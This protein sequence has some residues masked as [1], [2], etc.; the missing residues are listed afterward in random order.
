ME[1][2][3]ERELKKISKFD[4]LNFEWWSE[5]CGNLLGHSDV[6][7][8]VLLVCAAYFIRKSGFFEIDLDWTL[9]WLEFESISMI[10]SESELISVPS[11]K[12]Q[13]KL[14][15]F[16]INSRDKIGIQIHLLHVL[17]Q[18]LIDLASNLNFQIDFSILDEILNFEI[19]IWFGFCKLISNWTGNAKYRC[20]S[21]WDR[22]GATLILM[23][24]FINLDVKTSCLQ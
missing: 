2:K 15:K 18:T 11:L 3:T 1:F 21:N 7:D 9:T 12:I 19:D 24:E 8:I 22:I 13:F 16:C 14:I 10:K 5:A 6:D 20:G 17:I 4:T 23:S